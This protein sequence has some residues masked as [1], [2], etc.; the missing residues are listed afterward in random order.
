MLTKRILVLWNQVGEDIYE[1]WKREGVSPYAWDPNASPDPVETVQDEIDSLVSGLREAGYEVRA[2]N[3][4]DDL[5][6]LIEEIEGFDPHAIFNLVEYFYDDEG[7]EANVAALYE[8]L[9]YPYTGSRPSTLM[10]CQNKIRTKMLLQEAGLPTPRY[11]VVQ[12]EPVADPALSGLEYP[13]IVKPGFEDASGGIEEESVVLDYEQ[14]VARVKHVLGVWEQPAL[15]EEYID[16]REIHAAVLGDETLEVLPLF[17]MDFEEEEEEDGDEDLEDEDLEDEDLED[18]DLEDEDLEDE[19]EDEDEDEAACEDEDWEDEEEEEEWRPRIIS[20]SAK[21]DPTSEAFY[22]MDGVCPAEVEPD[23]EER[24]RTIV[25]QAFRVTE[26]RDYARVDL[27]IDEDG[28]PFILEVNPNPDLAQGGAYE[29]CAGAS[30][31]SYAQ[32]L[33]AIA[34]LAIGRGEPEIEET[35]T[36]TA[37]EDV[38]RET[39]DQMWQRHR[40]DRDAA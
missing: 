26:C 16:G 11:V 19:D 37:P 7:L 3:T 34:E 40:R 32:T 30:G 9:G 10:T 39:T 29:T 14:L 27:R 15:V 25:K 36:E 24:I 5:D 22:T 28:N 31:R 2:V 38:K 1:Q 23:L 13:L 21:W 18:E 35:G 8:L 33:A 17:E 6:K 12:Q 20:F 4:Q